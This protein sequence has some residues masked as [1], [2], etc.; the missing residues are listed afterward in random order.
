MMTTPRALLRNPASGEWLAFEHP[1]RTLEARTVDAVLD[2]LKAAE[3]A[4]DA[5]CWAVGY[6]SYE[7]AAAFDPALV[8]HP[9]TA[10]IPLVRFDIY[11]T[12]TVVPPPVGETET[13]QTALAGQH[14]TPSINRADYTQ[15]LSTIRDLIEAGDSYQVNFTYQLK[16]PA[17]TDTA[18]LFAQLVEGHRP[19]CA[20]GL[21]YP[22]FSICSLSPELFFQ[23]DGQQVISRPMKGTARRAPLPE[24]DEAAGEALRN[25]SKNRAENVMIVDMIRND[26]GRVALPGSVTVPDL[27]ALERYPTVWQLTSTVAARTS[28]TTVDI[29]RALFPCASITGA[30]KT[31]TMQIITELES[32][33]RGIYCGAIG[34]FGPQQQAWFNVAIRTALID[35]QTSRLSYGVG[36]GIVWDSSDRDEY[37]ETQAK[38]AILGETP[39]HF[40]LL[41]TL[42]WD[43]ATGYLLLDRHL[44]RMAASASYFDYDFDDTAVRSNLQQAIAAASAAMRVRLLVDRDG[45]ITI[46][47]A[48]LDLPATDNVAAAPVRLRLAASPIDPASPFLYHKTTNRAV[49][50][51]LRRSA[52]ADCDDLI[53]WNRRGEV[54]ETTIANLVFTI[55]GQRVTP[56]LSAGL[57]AGTYRAE[58]LASGDLVERSIPVTQLRRLKTI[59]VINSVRGERPAQLLL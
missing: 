1:V 4:S 57:L 42:R 27:F 10:A 24:D 48:P 43:P 28:A 33:P 20:A 12:A 49:Y 35:R 19:P 31:R 51:T 37:A 29:L 38:A 36:G 17:P 22:D 54:T 8:T 34:L 55:D 5:G 50:E 7:A 18:T 39:P 25:S 26:L 45:T 23:R 6:I 53:L 41:E 14:A 47:S 58:L 16:L 52:P 11:T 32:G 15:A 59:S 56:P 44:A 30:P 9:A 3:A 13:T 2:I 46:E 40:Q 21:E